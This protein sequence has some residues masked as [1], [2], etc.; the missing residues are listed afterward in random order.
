MVDDL[1]QLSMQG[2]RPTDRFNVPLLNLKHL[3]RIQM[4]N[5]EFTNF[6]KNNKVIVLKNVFINTFKCI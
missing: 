2:R 5:F 3:S 4:I 6:M 1:C